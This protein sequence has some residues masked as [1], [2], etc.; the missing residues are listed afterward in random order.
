MYSCQS[1]ITAE[2]QEVAN[3][4]AIGQSITVLWHETL[5]Q[6]NVLLQIFNLKKRASTILT[7]STNKTSTY[8][9]DIS[10]A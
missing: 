2:G 5:T 6:V 10:D 8:I 1:I 3:E 4:T 9:S 7:R